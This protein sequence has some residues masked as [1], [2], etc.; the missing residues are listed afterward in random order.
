[1]PGTFNGI[2]VA[3]GALRAFQRGMDITGH[4]LG[5]ISTRGYSRQ[6]VEYRANDAINFYQNGTMSLGQGVSIQSINRIR[7]TFLDSRMQAA[8]GDLGRFQTLSTTLR[9]IEPVFNEPGA[10][11]IGNALDK[12][13][14]AWSGLATNPGDAAS[15]IEVQ[16]SGQTLANR[17]RGTFQNL[18]A[19]QSEL[20]TQINSTVD[21]IN[22]LSTRIADLNREI[23][24]NMASGGVPNDLLDA[25]DLAVEDLS[26]LVN[27]NTS[28]L[29]SGEIAVHFGGY[30]LVDGTGATPFPSGLSTS[31]Y[32]TSDGTHQFPIRSGKLFGLMEASNKVTS[33][34]TQLNDLANN[35][36]SEINLLHQTGTNM[37]AA[38]NVDFFAVNLANPNSGALDFDLSAP[39]KADVKNIAAGTTGAAGDG[40]LALTLSNLRNGAIAGLGT[41][42]FSSFYSSMIA[43]VGR[44]VEFADQSLATQDA[45]VGQVD[46][47]RQSVS[48]VSI[49]DEMANMMKLQRSYQAAAKALS[50]FDQMT[51]ELIGLI[52]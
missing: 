47:Q 12:F 45:L 1:M 20:S 37:N 40:S 9:Q 32:M 14:N 51:E 26:A 49:D 36:R 28:Q 29:P 34:Q 52:R 17:I 27:V 35:L 42:T 19:R 10:N 30:P 2:N 21:Q 6:T 18:Q 38:T 4:N 31:T 8:S 13:F 7:D 39:V 5:N 3:S 50:A 22:S 33:Y 24:E 46:A 23:R 11:G 25:R 16:Q 48:G 43:T 41:K 44:D 15:R